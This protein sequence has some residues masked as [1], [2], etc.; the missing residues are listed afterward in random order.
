MSKAEYYQ[1]LSNINYNYTIG[2]LSWTDYREAVRLLR[3][4]RAA[5]GDHWIFSK[6]AA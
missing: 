2:G 5:S 4:E 3:A 1:T 6:V